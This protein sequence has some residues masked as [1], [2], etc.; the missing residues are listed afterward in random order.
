MHVT[1]GDSDAGFAPSFIEKP[2]I[3]PNES[4][5]LITMK[6]KCKAKPKPNVTWFRES[7]AVKESSKVK[8]KII[9]LEEEKYELSLEIK[10]HFNFHLVIRANILITVTEK[11]LHLIFSLFYNVLSLFALQYTILALFR[12]TMVILCITNLLQHIRIHNNTRFRSSSNKI[13]RF[14]VK[15]LPV[16]KCNFRS[17]T[18]LSFSRG[19]AKF[20][21]R[22]VIWLLEPAI[23]HLH[24]CFASSFFK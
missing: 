15:I 19:F 21:L 5:T 3:I 20:Y 16:I 9:E 14:L 18:L 24:I 12:N 22:C 6:C 10:V 1:G 4:G 7:V 11:Y 8:I 13:S 2:K 17:E 23:F